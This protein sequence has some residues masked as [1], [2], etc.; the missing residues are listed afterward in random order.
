MPAEA[1]LPSY[2][3]LQRKLSPVSPRA[4]RFALLRA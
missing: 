1:A 2:A 4:W 3:D